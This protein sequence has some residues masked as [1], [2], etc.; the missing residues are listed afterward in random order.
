MR[1]KHFILL[2][3]LITATYSYAQNGSRPV[4]TIEVQE[5]VMAKNLQHVVAPQLPSGAIGKCSNAM[6]TLNVT[7]DETG[8]VSIVDYVS[9]YDELKA[10]SLAAVKQWT[11]KPYEQHAH[12]VAVRTRVS[13]FYLGDGQSFPV[14]SP[15]STGG[16]KGGN[17]IPLPPGCGSGPLINRTPSA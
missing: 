14:Y 5:K 2:F 15:D 3:A 6:V 7:I 10:S 4:K 16:V 13:I 11:Y 12:P 17:M 8:Q 1:L 9:G